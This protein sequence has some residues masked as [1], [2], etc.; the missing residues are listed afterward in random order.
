[1]SA[2][3][4]M[5]AVKNSIAISTQ[6][7]IPEPAVIRSQ[8]IDLLPE[9]KRIAPGKRVIRRPCFLFRCRLG[10]QQR[11][12]ACPPIGAIAFTFGRVSFCMAI[13]RILRTGTNKEVAGIDAARTITAMAEHHSFG[14]RTMLKQPGEVVRGKVSAL[15]ANLAI[16]ARWI[17]Q[18]VPA[19]IRP[20]SIYLRPEARQVFLRRRDIHSCMFCKQPANSYSN[21]RFYA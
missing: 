12:S 4:P 14:N 2:P 7:P 9:A 6:R 1:M 8:N 16:L 20:A 10:A 11:K 3:R 17:S 19:V 21:R 15:N 13:G 18:P 5:P